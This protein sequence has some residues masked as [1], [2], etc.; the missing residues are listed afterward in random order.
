M[1]GSVDHSSVMRGVNIVPDSERT[2][3]VN[4]E[5]SGWTA[6]F[7]DFSN[8]RRDDDDDGDSFGTS[9]MVSD[10]A[11]I[12]AWNK[13]TTSPHHSNH[14]VVADASSCSPNFPKKLTFKK[15]RAKEISYDDSLEDTASSPVNSPKVSDFGMADRNPRKTNDHFNS[16]LRKGGRLEH[17]GGVLETNERCEMSYTGNNDRTDLKKRGLCLV[18]LSMLVNYLG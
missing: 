14:V 10:A 8:Q 15:I 12:P 17:Y 4:D 5:E 13:S 2:A 6:Y 3:A 1:E 16:S 9:S 7:E 11:S 18:P